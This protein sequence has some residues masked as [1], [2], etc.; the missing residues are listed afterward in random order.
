MVEA[1][2][3]SDYTRDSECDQR[4][5]SAEVLCASNEVAV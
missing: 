1:E 3:T 5:E 2:A 4:Q